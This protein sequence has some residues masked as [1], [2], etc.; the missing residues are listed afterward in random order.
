VKILVAEDESVTR[1]KLVTLLSRWGYEVV[2]TQDGLVAWDILQRE[3]APRLAIIDWMMPGMD[4]LQL[5]RAVRRCSSGSYLYILLLTAKNRQ[6]DIVAGL[7]AG[8]D[9]YV[10]KPFDAHELQIRLRAARRILDLQAELLSACEARR[11]QATHDA[12]TGVLNRRTVVEGLQRELARAQRDRTS[13]GVILMD[14]DH[15]KR[16]NDTYGH[17]MGDLVLREAVQR[18]QRE[19]RAHDLLGRYGGEEFLVVLPTC[20]TAEAEKVGERLRQCLADTPMDLPD[21]PLMVTG[22]FG[23]VSST[24]EGEDVDTLLRLV[25]ASL[26]RA[27]REGRN[28]VIVGGPGTRGRNTAG[29]GNFSL[30]RD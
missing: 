26:Y 5:C 14:L 18:L 4:G 10:T 17:P 7:D 29:L 11:Q 12:L 1:T 28:R 2:E 6:E 19:L 22:S 25:D 30:E 8:A 15:F 21:G 16:I 9:D 13:V 3:D 27:K 20:S 23:V 24:G